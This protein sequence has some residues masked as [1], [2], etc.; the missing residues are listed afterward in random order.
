MF[1]WRCRPA[2]R[3]SSPDSILLRNRW[4]SS[5]ARVVPAS[6]IFNPLYSGGLWLPATAMVRGEISDRGCEHPDLRDVHAACANALRQ[7]ASELG[8]GD[9]T[10]AA[11]CDLGPPAPAA[12]V[13][14]LASERL[15]DQPNAFAGEGFADDAADVIGLE[16]FRRRK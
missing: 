6:T 12:A 1:A 3:A 9:P 7:R 14:Q 8:S 5:P 2:P 11:H 4:T 16:D 15:P 10:V 13:E